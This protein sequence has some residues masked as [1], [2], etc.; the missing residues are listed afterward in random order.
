MKNTQK[1]SEILNYNLVDNIEFDFK[2][3]II[4]LSLTDTVLTKKEDNSVIKNKIEE[5][6]D[7]I[8]KN[9]NI[10]E[11]K[12]LELSFLLNKIS[13]ILDEEDD[14][15][16]IEINNDKDLIDVVFEDLVSQQLNL[17]ID[18]LEKEIKLN[19]NDYY[20][21]I[22]SNIILIN[23]IIKKLYD[24]QT[25]LFDKITEYYYSQKEQ[26]INN[27]N[28][29]NS[30]IEVNTNTDIISEFLSSKSYE[31]KTQ[32]TLIGLNEDINKIELIDKNDKVY[33]LKLF[34]KEAVTTES[35]KILYINN[36]INIDYIY[37]LK[38]L[39][40]Q[41]LLNSKPKIELS[42]KHIIYTDGG[43][44]VTMNEF[45]VIEVLENNE[46]RITGLDDNKLVFINV[47]FSSFHFLLNE[48]Y[49]LIN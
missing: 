5:L 30:K 40:L 42:K 37:H 27:L 32:N 24:N 19:I 43:I 39:E 7:E 49:K 38:T 17:T 44:I 22:N 11:E 29:F 8:G 20:L 48:Y 18:I 6:S 15:D 36:L 26:Y 10:T 33:T 41:K 28:S 4:N 31:F 34:S 2:S 9:D 21:K 35:F 14:E 47:K 12:E 16:V 3:N 23:E 13:N 1:I 45:E 25:G 46:Y